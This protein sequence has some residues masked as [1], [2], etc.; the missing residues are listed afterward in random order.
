M[1]KLYAKWMYDWENR[2]CPAPP[3]AWCGRSNGGWSG[4]RSGRSPNRYPANGHDPHAYLQL[5]NR[6]ALESSDEF[7][8]YTPPTD[9][10]LDGNLL[11]FTSAVET[12]YPKTTGCTGNG[13]RRSDKP[14]ARRVAAV[15]LPHWN[16]SVTQHNALCARAGE[17]R[18]LGAAPEPAVSRLPHAGRTEARRL[19][20]VLE[21]RP[22]HRR[23][24][25]GR[26]RHALRASTGWSRRATSA[27][28]L[29]APAWVPAT[30]SW[31]A[32]TTRG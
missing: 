16:A 6:S 10:E 22:H 12:P 32:R 4:P 30:R 11:R 9:F 17:A 19:R 3:I 25:A 29:S 27:S 14:G 1:G 28:A 2:L 26:D 13:F 7:F 15:V 8:A 5:L 23:D 24:P 18:D 20:G 21:H 31:R